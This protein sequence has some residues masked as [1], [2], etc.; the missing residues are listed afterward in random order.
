[1]QTPWL[2]VTELASAL[3]LSVKT[4]QRAYRKG[5]IPVERIFRF[6]RF[7]VQEVKAAMRRNGRGPG[8]DGTGQVRGDRAT[9]G[10]RRRRTSPDSPRPV[11]RGRNFQ[12]ARRRQG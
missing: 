5:E 6:V 3:K 11:K 4:V 9:G 8:E 2:T 12:Q 7:D 10:N 1:M